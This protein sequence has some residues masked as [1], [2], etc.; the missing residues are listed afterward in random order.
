MRHPHKCIYD[1]TCKT[2]A[3]KKHFGYVSGNTSAHNWFKWATTM[4]ENQTRGAF[5]WLFSVAMVALY[6]GFYA[7]AR[8]SCRVCITDGDDDMIVALGGAFDVLDAEGVRLWGSHPAGVILRRCHFHLF[9]LNFNDFYKSFV[10]RDG[11]VGMEVRDWFVYA[12]IH[13]ETQTEFLMAFKAIRCAVENKETTAQFSPAAQ[14]QLLCWLDARRLDYRSYCR[15]VISGVVD[16]FENTTNAGESA[17]HRL[18][19]DVEVNNKAELRVVARSDLKNVAQLYAEHAAMHQRR[20]LEVALSAIPIEHCARTHLCHHAADYVVKEFVESKK[21]KVSECCDGSGCA[22]VWRAFPDKA[23]EA[24]SKYPFRFNRGPRL[25]REDSNGRIICPCPHFVAT[26]KV[27]RHIIAFNQGNFEPEDV[28]PR[29]LKSYFV[30]DAMPDA[31]PF[32]GCVNRRSPTAIFDALSVCNDDDNSNN[33]DDGCDDHSDSAP[34]PPRQR[35]HM[36]SMLT[37]KSRALIEKWNDVP[38]AASKLMRYFEGFDAEMG[39]RDSY[40]VAGGATS[41]PTP[42]R[43]SY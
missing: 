34:Q 15:F 42:S 43:G 12:V 16:D 39:E 1:T 24:R 21:Y 36:Y 9:T 27:C 26:Q 7:F 4:L 40:R 13:A 3:A 8:L 19:S 11:N 10:R 35:G 29:H 25:L 28:H 23:D 14:L 17:H 37:Q 5:Y 38:V 6:H 33:N 20:A 18:K 2:N 30:T 41:R 32:L 22:L 31:S